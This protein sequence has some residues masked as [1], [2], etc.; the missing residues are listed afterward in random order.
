MKRKQTLW[1]ALLL[2]LCLAACAAP[3]P[4]YAGEPVPGA[5][6]GCSLEELGQA[7]GL[8][9]EDLAGDGKN[10]YTLTVEDIEIYGLSAEE[11]SLTFTLAHTRDALYPAPEEGGVYRLGQI[12]FKAADPAAA[13]AAFTKL[14]GQP[15]EGDASAKWL[16]EGSAVPAE[17]LV[18]RAEATTSVAYTDG[19]KAWLADIRAALRDNGVPESML[20]LEEASMLVI[21]R[22]TNLP[23][24][25]TISG[26]Y[27]MYARCADLEAGE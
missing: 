25:F 20:P 2:L 18:W 10:W 24:E 22:K 4:G 21:Y 8:P 19:Q 17:T 26:I 1:P 14:L 7:L 3:A 5:A 23:A 13:A 15:R 12:S 16:E 6:W 9:A 27:Q 11:A